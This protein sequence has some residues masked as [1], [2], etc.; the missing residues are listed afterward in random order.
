LSTRSASIAEAAERRPHVYR[1]AA[2]HPVGRIARRHIFASAPRWSVAVVLGTGLLVLA[3]LASL[4][5]TALGAGGDVAGQLVADILPGALA[6]TALL[7]GGIAVLAGAVGTGAA[8][9]VTAH[10]FPFRRALA[11]LLPLPLAVP[12]Y[13]TAY[14]YVDLL[15]AAG[16]LQAAL[17]GLMGWRSR[18]DYWFPEVRSLAGCILVMSFVLYPYVYIT[19]RAMFLTQ[20]AAMMEVARTLGAS[21]FE[22]FRTVAVPLARPALAVGLSLALLEA[23]NDIGAAEYLGVRTLTVSVFTTWLNRGSLPVAAQIACA[24]LAIVIGLIL[25]ERR[26]RQNRGYA[27]SARR[28]RV[29]Q[30]IR[31]TPFAGM[32]ALV[33]CALP[34]VLGF[35]IPAAFLVGEVAGRGLL[36]QVDLTF[37]RHVATTLGL[38]ASAT[39]AAL[40]LAVVVVTASRFAQHQ[41]MD[42]LKVVVGLG[43]A[44]PGT[45][46]ALGLLGPLVAFDTLINLVWRTLGGERLGLVLM[47]SAGAIVVA[48]VVRFLP[49]A[50]GSL[51][52]G[53][54]RLSAGVDDAAR[55]LGAKPRELVL[56]VQLPMLR[57]ALASAALLVFVDCLKE[58]PA[59]LLLRPLNT[60]T[61]ATLVYGQASRGS[62]EDGSLAALVI[63]L[64]GIWPVMRLTRSAEVRR[65]PSPT[66]PFP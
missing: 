29:A 18:A 58:L 54:D 11:W 41:I 10:D 3:P 51:S 45:V 43:Y 65:Q 24:M 21:R 52:A 66:L 31:L 63:I 44:V 56:R 17:R 30:P 49:I 20:S 55:T 6:E 5:A 22:L 50:T 38:A 13:I 46:L 15:D 47:G 39:A 32:L 27:T 16:P 60:E 64:V 37:L 4:V 2:P 53:L 26:G 48:Y 19:A 25:I 42:A 59:T 62:F 28:A 14:V 35:L 9:L 40:L 1:A 57:P 7:L 34:V 33:A 61:L 8:W 36:A 23:L 12:T